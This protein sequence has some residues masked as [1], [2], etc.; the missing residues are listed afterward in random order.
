MK[1]YKRLNL[2]SLAII[3]T[4]SLYHYNLKAQCVGI[5]T[6]TPDSSAV[7]DINSDSLGLLIP[8]MNTA[9]LQA[10]S[11]PANGLLAFDTD[12]KTIVMYL[13]NVDKWV[14]IMNAINM[15]D[16]VNAIVERKSLTSSFTL[17]SDMSPSLWLSI[18]SLSLQELQIASYKHRAYMDLT[19]VDSVRLVA[20][21]SGITF[22]LF[23]TELTLQLQ[24][25]TD[26]VN[27]FPLNS[28]GFGGPLLSTTVDGLVKT[29]WVSLDEAAKDDVQVRIAGKSDAGIILQAGLGLVVIETK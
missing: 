14:P 2:I 22:D 6:L 12:Q 28:E 10:I 11:T 3:A 24:Y 29:D 21:V 1:F 23:S 7:L 8:R 20:N 4:L 27:W 15:Q 19:N 13:S 25:S 26:G 17:I 18:G 16:T 9:S 5:N